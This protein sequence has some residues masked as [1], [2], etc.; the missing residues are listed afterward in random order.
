MLPKEC[1]TSIGLSFLSLE[2]RR[3][4]RS[5]TNWGIEGGDLKVLNPDPRMSSLSIVY[6]EANRL[7]RG[8]KEL[9]EPPRPCINTI[10]GPDPYSSKNMREPLVVVWY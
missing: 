7:I 8:W 1:P 5:S 10:K 6:L 3:E 4:P 9:T 2:S